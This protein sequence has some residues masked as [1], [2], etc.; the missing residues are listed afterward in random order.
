MQLVAVMF[1]EEQL[2]KAEWR[3]FRKPQWDFTS[4]LRLQNAAN[5]RCNV[6]LAEGQEI[7]EEKVDPGMTHT[8]F[9]PHQAVETPTREGSADPDIQVD[10]IFLVRPT[11]VVTLGSRIMAL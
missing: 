11:G 1:C 8:A 4:Y 5:E 9:N 7:L 3:C 10:I 6:Y 2:I